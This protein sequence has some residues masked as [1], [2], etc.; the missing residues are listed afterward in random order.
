MRIFLS[1]LIVCLLCL[2]NTGFAANSV[3]VRAGIHDRYNRLVF[4]W[5]GRVDFKIDA[6][7][8]QVTIQFMKT[9]VA[10]FR[11]AIATNPPFIRHLAQQSNNNGLLVTFEIP[12]KMKIESFRTDEGGIA[13]DILRMEKDPPKFTDTKAPPVPEKP[14]ETKPVAATPVDLSGKPHLETLA[15]KLAEKP[16]ESELQDKNGVPGSPV[17]PQPEAIKGTVI[18]LSPNELTRLAVFVRG[19]KLWLVLDKPLETLIPSI[20]GEDVDVLSKNAHRISLPNAAAFTFDALPEGSTR[21]TIHRQSNQWQIWMNPAD[22]PY[23]PDNIPVNIASSA[24]DQPPVASLYA[25]ENASV[26]TLKDTQI[27]D[28]LWVV[29]M[30]T[31]EGRIISLHTTPDYQILPSLMGAVI[32]PLT[33]AVKVETQSDKVLLSANADKKLSF[34]DDADRKRGIQESSYVPIFNLNID[35]LPDGTFSDK[36]Q[37]IETRLVAQKTPEDKAKALLDLAR[38]DISYGFGPEALGVMRIA[39]SLNPTIKTVSRTYEALHGMAAALAGDM[40]LAKID[41]SNDEIQSQ[42]AAKLWLG[43]VLANHYIWEQAHGAFAESGNVINSMPDSLKPRLILAEAEASMQAGDLADTDRLLHMIDKKFPMTPSDQAA[44][45]YIEA[46]AALKAKNVEDSTPIFEKLRDGNDRLYKVKAQMAL[47][48]Q[49]LTS[50]KIELPEAIKR[51]ER[52]RFDWRNDRLEIDILRQLGQFYVDNKQY[53]DGL[54]IWRSAA[55]LSKISDD[56][57]AITT[58]MQKVFSKLYVDGDADKMSP[59]EAVAL[60]ERFRELTPSGD[61]GNIALSHLADRLAAVDLLDQADALLEKQLLQN[62]KGEDAAKVGA[63]LAT[64]R[65]LDHNPSGALKALD[66]STQDVSLPDSLSQKR[67]LLRARALADLNKTD[68]ALTLLGT[69]QSPES[70]SLKADIAWRQNRWGDTV[71]ALQPLIS[72]YRDAGKTAPNGPMP[73]LILKMAIAIALDENKK[74]ME[75]MIAQ[76][77]EYMT[78][79]PQAQAFKM[80]TTP[81]GNGS[82]ADMDTLKNQVGQVELFQTFLK[83]FGS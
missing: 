82:L 12:E 43:Y 27:G 24:P 52:L 77:G 58:S 63:K 54:D 19:G 4:D 46:N 30:R 5:H 36:R 62:A 57:D 26:I 50:K 9:G 48:Q 75:L 13:F 59:L 33:D 29:P 72:I 61:Q 42:P 23:L 35:N 1:A 34:S 28:R 37:D 40:E 81:S 47:T 16:P 71:D 39:R 69:L 25:G 67:L 32:V 6:Q 49:Q 10:D 55:G 66:E 83:N 65:L 17:S 74:G 41:L 11:S 20:E 53:M 31:P 73:P 70:Y 45:E 22:K 38:L 64:W 15:D 21:Y 79:T 44:Y 68:E 8:N 3:K 14:A 2:P 51:Y 76:Y 60:F 78:T 7:N 56:T 80:I 18:K